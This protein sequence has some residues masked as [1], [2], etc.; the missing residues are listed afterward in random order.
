M[1]D[2]H[3]ALMYEFLLFMGQIGMVSRS[4][5]QV[6]MEVL[7]NSIIKN[8]VVTLFVAN[9]KSIDPDSSVLRN[10]PQYFTNEYLRNKVESF[11]QSH[12]LSV[13]YICLLPDLDP[14]FPIERCDELWQMNL[15]QIRS[16]T[17]A[18]CV[19]LSMLSASVEVDRKFVLR[20][21]EK[22]IAD[23]TERQSTLIEFHADADFAAHQIVNYATAGI[24][25]EEIFPN[26]ILL[27]IQKRSYPFEQPYYSRLRKNELPIVYCGQKDGNPL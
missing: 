15:E 26:G 3:A 27:D 5:A 7:A 21:L 17:S 25:F 10:K 23:F 8:G 20:T 4:S 24:I 1:E 12:D 18:K 14:K 2:K 11:V 6:M 9:S 22:E 13:E 16:Y 19:R